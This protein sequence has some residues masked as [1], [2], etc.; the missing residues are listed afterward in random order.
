M[1]NLTISGETFRSFS[2]FS[3]SRVRFS[4]NRRF[5]SLWRRKPGRFVST[6]LTG[7]RKKKIAISSIFPRPTLDPTAELSRGE[8]F[9]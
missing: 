3:A 4:A 9:E 2:D 8:L 1:A 5:L 7:Q 6:P